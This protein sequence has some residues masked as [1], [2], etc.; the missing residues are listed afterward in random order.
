MAAAMKTDFTWDSNAEWRIAGSHIYT[1]EGL[2][3]TEEGSDDPLSKNGAMLLASR[4]PEQS[5][6]S[7]GWPRLEHPISALEDNAWSQT[8]DVDRAFSVG[9]SPVLQSSSLRYA[10][11]AS[12]DS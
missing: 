9:L 8:H 11:T 1:L 5:A 3:R 7:Y 10:S 4:A 6:E 12:R 2:F